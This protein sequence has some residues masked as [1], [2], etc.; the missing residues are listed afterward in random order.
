MARGRSSTTSTPT[1]SAATSQRPSDE[2]QDELN[3]RLLASMSAKTAVTHK[4]QPVEESVL[5][6][7][8]CDADACVSEVLA[9]VAGLE[10]G[11]QVVTDMMSTVLLQLE[12]VKTSLAL[13]QPVQ[14]QP[15]QQHQKQ[16]AHEQEEQEQKLQ[17]PALQQHSV[18]D[19]EGCTPRRSGIPSEGSASSPVAAAAAADSSAVQE[20]DG[21]QWRIAGPR[22]KPDRGSKPSVVV[23]IALHERIAPADL[24]AK[25]CSRT[26]QIHL[27][28]WCRTVAPGITLWNHATVGLVGNRLVSAKTRVSEREAQSLLDKSGTHWVFCARVYSLQEGAK[29]VPMVRL[30]PGATHANALAVRAAAVAQ[31]I[32]ANLVA[33]RSGYALRVSEA[34]LSAAQGVVLEEQQQQELQQ[35]QQP[36]RKRQVQQ[37]HSLQQPSVSRQLQRQLQRQQQPQYQRPQLH[38]RALGQGHVDPNQEA[39]LTKVEG[40]VKHLL[41][42][43]VDT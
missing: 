3:R 10:K 33:L 25:M 13:L 43:L 31:G 1:S 4:V 14:E 22:R 29:R 24:W 15:V 9:K 34:D 6:D 7:S 27:Q 2:Q 16:L 40:R 26:P 5:E 11:L 20:H 38:E 23:R 12:E 18:P 39:R 35:Q 37:Q 21:G 19:S 32:T 42:L 30:A 28:E 36:L 8:E 17:Q 41:A